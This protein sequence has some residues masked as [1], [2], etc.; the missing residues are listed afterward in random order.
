MEIEMHLL[1]SDGK[2]SYRANEVIKN[3]KSINKNIPIVKEC[4]KNMVEFGCYPTVNTISPAL[5]MI[6]SI[7]VTNEYLEKNNLHFYP[8]ATY[9]GKIKSKFTESGTYNIKKKIFGDS[10]NI[11]PRVTSMH[12]HYSLPKGVFDT[13]KKRLRLFKQSKLKRSLINSYNLEIA[14]DPVLTLF[15]QSSP[16][17]EGKYLAKDSRLV[18]YRGGKKLR[19][20]EG[21]YANHRSLGHLPSY[22]HNQTDL[23]LQ[24]KRK[25]IM[26]KR[27]I[28]KADP[29]ADFDKI[30]P[31]K[32]DIGWT[33][34]KVN[35]HGTLEQRG[36]DMN[37]LST[38]FSVST[39]IKYSLRKIQREF[40][41]I[42]PTDFGLSNAFKE[43]NGLMYIPPH[44]TILNLQKASAYDGLAN[45]TLYEYS[46]RYLN[47]T[48]SIIPKKYQTL[49]KPISE[50]IESKKTM[51][52]RILSYS[53][54][55]GYMKGDGKISTKG[56]KAVALYSNSLFE[57]D[58]NRIKKKLSYI[59]NL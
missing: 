48:K 1:E 22:V 20:P 12:H 28:K 17:F 32:L 8:F 59:S 44:G 21:L 13:N 3:V 15:T 14:L 49:I 2:I 54:R 57:K 36:M 55:K 37:L 30:Y 43:E 35:K 47:F 46:K 33:P 42:I 5:D 58:L 4:G 41:E 29:K 56:S 19:Y 31:T 10:F 25:Q 51:S 18:T 52:D 38:L 16:F 11:A 24:N 9:P 45:K 34:V 26:M 53:K 40:I 7:E 23:M 6:N 39:M 50:M 27:L